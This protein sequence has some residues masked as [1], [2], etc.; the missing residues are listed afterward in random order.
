MVDG[1]VTEQCAGFMEDS[2]KYPDVIVLFI[3]LN[4]INM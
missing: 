3:C 4:T 1:V 2:Y